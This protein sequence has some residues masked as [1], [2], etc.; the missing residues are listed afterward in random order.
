VTLL[1]RANPRLPICV[2][3]TTWCKHLP[4]IL[5]L[6]PKSRLRESG[7]LLHPPASDILAMRHIWAANLRELGNVLQLLAPDLVT[8]AQVQAAELRESG[9]LLHPPVFDVLAMR[10][11]WAADLRELDNVVQA[12]ARSLVAAA[13][14]QPGD[15][16]ES[17]HVLHPLVSDV[18]A[19][20]QL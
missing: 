19:I 2:S 16:R 15:L 3:W 9:H 12:L 1:Q 14:V 5:S 10:Q 8:A 4:V 18:P 6:P 13:Q 20:R 7:H 11:F 17:G